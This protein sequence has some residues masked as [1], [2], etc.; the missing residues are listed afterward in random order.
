MTTKTKPRFRKMTTLEKMTATGWILTFCVTIPL[1]A[2]LTLGIV[3]VVIGLISAL[4]GVSKLGKYVEEVE[5]NTVIDM[6][7]DLTGET[8]VIELD[9][10][11][12]KITFHSYRL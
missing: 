7:R 12:I 1:I 5:D 9:D 4:V 3:G 10:E 11:K 2:S 8:P 6:Q